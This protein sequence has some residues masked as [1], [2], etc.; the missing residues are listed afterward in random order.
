MQSWT[1][2]DSLELYNVRLWSDGFFS[3]NDEGHV[4][5][6]PRRERE[7]SIDLKGLV[8]DL[9]ERG[10]DLPLLLRFTDI[11][12]ERVKE[13]AGCF[14]QAMREYGYK[15]R[16]QGVYPIKVNQQSRVVEDLLACLAPIRDAK[17]G[18]RLSPRHGHA[19]FTAGPD[20][21]P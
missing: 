2:Q 20:L 12:K 21:T 5:A 3:I 8:E 11:L 10:Y 4:V 19:T 7:P 1:I 13:I 6:L 15:G 9:R 16:Y 14:G 17:G 18:H